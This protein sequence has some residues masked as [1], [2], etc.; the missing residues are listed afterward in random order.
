MGHLTLQD[1]LIVGN[2]LQQVK[3]SE[4]TL[5]MY[6]MLQT[7]EREPTLT[8]E[9]GKHHQNTK[10]VKR[11]NPHKYLLYKPTF[12]QFTT[13]LSTGMKE[14]PEDGALLL[15]LSADPAKPPSNS[16][17]E[18]IAYDLG[19]VATNSKKDSLEAKKKT[20]ML[21]DVH[22]IHPG[23]LYPF[24]RRPL[25]LIIDS[26]NSDA[27]RNFPNLFGQP[28]VSLMS[29]SFLPVTLQDESANKG[30][31]FTLFL[32]SPLMGF[33]Y[34]SAIPDVQ[35]SL[36]GNCQAMVTKILADLDSQIIRSKTVDVAFKQFYGDDFLRLLILRFCFCYVTLR[37]HRGFKDSS[38]YPQSFPD[39][40]GH[41]ILESQSV[42]KLLL[43]LAAMLD[44][45]PVFLEPG[46]LE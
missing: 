45:R 24:S 37:Y 29:P 18:D 35:E 16:K 27:F 15:Y 25:F 46:E 38:Y 3:F 2:C 9:G 13:Y 23:D 19:G 36:W 8:M 33:C 17:G 22:C 31:L 41:E 39:L 6:H 20:G 32:H 42:H 10:S 4:L 40:R 1:A 34:V 44:I 43:D 7:I 28:L 21:K 26:P 30:N 11:S 5:D 14:L 12:G